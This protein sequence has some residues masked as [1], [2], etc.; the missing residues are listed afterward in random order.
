MIGVEEVG[1]GKV[2]S[3]GQVAIPSE[4]REKMHLKEGEKVLFLL[5]GESLL[6]KKIGSVS[7]R[8]VTRPLRGARKSITEDEATALVHRLR[9][10]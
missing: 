10:K 6:V 1:V 7:W 8:E 2:S 5:K 4:I 9:K 3:R